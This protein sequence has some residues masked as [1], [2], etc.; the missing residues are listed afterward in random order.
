MHNFIH[1]LT[2]LFWKSTMSQPWK[3]YRKYVGV[4]RIIRNVRGLT[5][6]VNY[7]LSSERNVYKVNKKRASLYT[8]TC[9][10]HVTENTLIRW[11]KQ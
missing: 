4:D 2:K 9:N 8:C 6:G 10:N 11:E 1:S 5:F 3:C 7:G